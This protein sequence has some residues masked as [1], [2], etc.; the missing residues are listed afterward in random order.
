M[1]DL[2]SAR[3]RISSHNLR[4]ETGRHEKP[5]IPSEDRTCL[6]CN[7]NEVE[8]E[9]QSCDLSKLLFILRKSKYDSKEIYW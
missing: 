4:I 8:D 3:F 5:K 9:I 7:L 2:E 6:K 1:I